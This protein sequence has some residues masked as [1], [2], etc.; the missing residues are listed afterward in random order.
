M[1]DGELHDRELVLDTLVKAGG[2]GHREPIR[3]GSKK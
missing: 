3:G 2:L 1:E